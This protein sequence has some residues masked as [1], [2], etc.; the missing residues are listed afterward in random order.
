MLLRTVLA[1]EEDG[2][3]DFDAV[4]LDSESRTCSASVKNSRW[5]KSLAYVWSRR[6]YSNYYSPSLS[7]LN[8]I[9]SL[10]EVGGG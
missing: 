1:I 7:R 10:Y 5:K 3:T 6:K 2:I 4:G 9:I 8:I